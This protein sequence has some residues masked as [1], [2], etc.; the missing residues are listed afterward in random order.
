MHLHL[1]MAVSHHLNES[2]GLLHAGSDAR[3][4]VLVAAG[5]LSDAGVQSHTA[6]ASSGHLRQETMLST[7]SCKRRGCFCGRSA[8][9]I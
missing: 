9:A 4:E 7:V 2:A 6:A 3:E 1:A 8:L 5:L